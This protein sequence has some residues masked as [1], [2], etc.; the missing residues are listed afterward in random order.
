MQRKKLSSVSNETIRDWPR[1]PSIR[2]INA[3]NI[4]YGSLLKGDMNIPEDKEKARD[5]ISEVIDDNLSS[6]DLKILD[7]VKSN[8]HQNGFFN[9][10]Y[11][12]LYPHFVKL[13]IA[14][15]QRALGSDRESCPIKNYDFIINNSKS[16]TFIDSFCPVEFIIDPFQADDPSLVKEFSE[17]IDSTKGISRIVSSTH[18]FIA[19]RAITIFIN[20]NGEIEENVPKYKIVV[21]DEVGQKIIDKIN[22]DWLKKCVDIVNYDVSAFK[23]AS[24]KSDKSAI[25]EEFDKICDRFCF[26]S[27]ELIFNHERLSAIEK[28]NHA[29][30]LME[31]EFKKLLIAA[32]DRQ[33]NQYNAAAR[34]SNLHK[35]LVYDDK[36]MSAQQKIYTLINACATEYE[37]I[38]KRRPAST[39]AKNLRDF[40]DKTVAWNLPKTPQ[41]LKNIPRTPDGSFDLKSLVDN[42]PTIKSPVLSTMNIEEAQQGKI[43]DELLAKLTAHK[44]KLKAQLSSCLSFFYKSEFSLKGKKLAIIEDLIQYIEKGVYNKDMGKLSPVAKKKYTNVFINSSSINKEEAVKLALDGDLGKIVKQFEKSGFLPSAFNKH[45][46]QHKVK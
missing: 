44:I 19:S 30:N 35:K 18:F 24:I 2:F 6:V 46:H 7:Y 38:I 36:A 20:D 21:C 32:A 9:A 34:L 37:K 26:T 10:Y 31:E 16:I 13:G 5:T 25:R 22:P 1:V 42:D 11:P 29:F 17:Y 8:A 4:F 33:T 45:Q 12:E 14:L 27:M 41:E 43:K 40:V 23:D 39:F 15:S 3:G 28:M